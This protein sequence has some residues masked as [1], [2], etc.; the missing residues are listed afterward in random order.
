MLS[1]RQTTP[2]ASSGGFFRTP[3]EEIVLQSVVR[4]YP[5]LRVVL[6]HSKYKIFEPKIVGDTVTG[7]AIPPASRTSSLDTKDVVNLARTGAAVFF[8]VFADTEDVGTI[9]EL[10]K[11]FLCL[12]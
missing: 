12:W 10:V 1:L 2:P 9:G 4:S 7:F 5:R 8:T 11:V 3:L 6:Q